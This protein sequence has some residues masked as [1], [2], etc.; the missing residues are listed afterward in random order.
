VSLYC[1]WDSMLWVWGSE[2]VLCV[3]LF[4]VDLGE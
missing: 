3:G 2:F 1:V 4:G